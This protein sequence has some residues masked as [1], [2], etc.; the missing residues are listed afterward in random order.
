[1]NTPEMALVGAFLLLGLGFYG[2]LVMRHLIKMLIALQIMGKAALLV[3]IAAN[4][5]EVGLG[6]SLAVTVIVA[7]TLVAVVGMALAIQI[8]RHFGTLDIHQ[9]TLSEE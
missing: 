2:L 7:D 4:R 1:M 8:Q 5:D 6:Q 9:L 3:M